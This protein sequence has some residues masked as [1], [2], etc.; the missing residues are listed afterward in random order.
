MAG[1]RRTRPRCGART[2][3]GTPC[4][5]AALPNGRCKFHGGLSTGPRTEEGRRQSA[6]NLDRAREALARPELAELR[7]EAS[8]K[9]WVTRRI[10]K[11]REQLRRMAA[12]NVPMARE[13]LDH[14][15]AVIPPAAR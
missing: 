13:L 15:D 6:R 14:L 9:G 10:N 7:S 5:C 4:Q 11:R 8:R 2:R 3:R 12:A 1:R